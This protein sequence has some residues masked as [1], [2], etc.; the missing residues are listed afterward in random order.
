MSILE[1]LFSAY[2]RQIYVYVVCIPN[3]FG[4]HDWKIKTLYIS[5]YQFSTRED[6]IRV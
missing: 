5:I 6:K 1:K 3:I 2:Q 4:K